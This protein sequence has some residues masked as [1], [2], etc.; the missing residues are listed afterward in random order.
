MPIGLTDVLLAGAAVAAGPEVA[1]ASAVYEGEALL[2]GGIAAEVESAV[3]SNLVKRAAAVAGVDTALPAAKRAATVVAKFEAAKDVADEAARVYR[4][5]EHAAGLTGP[6]PKRVKRE[7]HTLDFLRTRLKG[8]IKD[9]SP[10]VSARKGASRKKPWRT[11]SGAARLGV[12]LGRGARSGAR[13]RWG[14][15]FRGLRRSYTRRR[16]Y[17]RRLTRGVASR[18]RRRR[19]STR[20]RRWGYR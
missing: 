12:G 17:G 1:A 3:S 20:R 5:A 15:G 11:G 4:N 2:S 6:S 9:T 14:S 8:L 18:W 13:R 7:H 19:F 16:V 10:K